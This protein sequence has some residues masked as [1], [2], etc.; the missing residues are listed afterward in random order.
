MRRVAAIGREPTSLDRQRHRALG[1]VVADPEV[2]RH[3]MQHDP[4]S[5]V[6]ARGALARQVLDG[7]AEAVG[8]IGLRAR[9]LGLHHRA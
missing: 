6:A 5:A 1:F 9:A 2:A 7:I 3:V 4:L 8:Q